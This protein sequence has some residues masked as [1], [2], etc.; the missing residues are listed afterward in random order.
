M[1]FRRNG[2]VP[3]AP[4]ILLPLKSQLS[5]WYGFLR[6]GVHGTLERKSLIF[7]Y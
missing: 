3:L 1:T 5:I 4:I 6:S 2:A 7:L